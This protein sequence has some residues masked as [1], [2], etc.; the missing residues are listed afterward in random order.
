M[1]AAFDLPLDRDAIERILPHRP[2]MLLIDR[3]M[4]LIPGERAVAERDVRADDPVFAGHYPGHPVYP[5][6]LITEAMAQAGAVA[7]LALPEMAGRMPFF[8]GIEKL[9]FRRPVLPGETLRLE[10]TLGKLRHGMG[11]GHAVATVGGELAAEGD[12]LFAI[13]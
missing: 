13:K 7:L 6:V 3:V 2:P 10:M 8:G 4:E 11:F 9:R 12:L 5:G 1:N